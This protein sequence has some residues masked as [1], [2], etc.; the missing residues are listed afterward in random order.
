MFVYEQHCR[1]KDSLSLNIP[2]IETL[3]AFKVSNMNFSG[4]AKKLTQKQLFQTFRYK[5]AEKA[6]AHRL[7]VISWN[8]L[9][10]PYNRKKKQGQDSWKG[11]VLGQ[12]D[13]LSSLEKTPDIIFLQEFWHAN[14]DYCRIWEEFCSEYGYS[15]FIGK[16]T[17]S[18]V[19]GC[20]T[21]L[22]EQKLQVEKVELFSY[23]DWGD[24][25]CVVLDC[26]GSLSGKEKK[27]S[28]FNTHLTFPH[29]NN[30][31]PIMRQHQARKLKE[32]IEASRN[33]D[34]TILLGGDLN[35]SINDRAIK[36]LFKDTL[37]PHSVEEGWISHR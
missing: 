12:R 27:I 4:P 21:L 33:Q 34:R 9:A 29:K 19:D 11:R 31:D 37:V 20:C 16:R 30:H 23:D 26:I 7:L 1:A 3:E 35:G 25:I 28:L 2:K 32:V 5:H 8:L 6:S 14:Q 36:E 13:Y 24:R 18:K 15:M 10:P 17:G 22:N